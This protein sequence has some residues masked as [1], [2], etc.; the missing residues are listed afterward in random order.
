MTTVLLIRHGLN[1]WVGKRL[2]GRTPDV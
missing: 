2:A 1:D